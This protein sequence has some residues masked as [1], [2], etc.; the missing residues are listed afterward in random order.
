[1]K[2]SRAKGLAFERKFAREVE[3]RWGSCAVPSQWLYFRDA[4]GPGYAQPDVYVEL[5]NR[6]LVFECKLT[7]TPAAWRQLYKLYA[8]LLG[9]L[10]QKRVVCVQVC[11]NL[12]DKSVGPVRSFGEISD[13][14]VLQWLGQPGVL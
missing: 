10:L 11:R 7:Y 5:A 12:F 8:P 3:K 1:M 6:V 4:N 13:G 2:G 14:E 9:E